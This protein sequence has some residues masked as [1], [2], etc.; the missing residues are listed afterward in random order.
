M[1]SLLPNLPIS[2]LFPRPLGRLNLLQTW[3]IMLFVLGCSACGDET[4]Q[5]IPP[6]TPEMSEDQQLVYL[7]TYTREESHVNGKASGIYA[8]RQDKENGKLE[9]ID[10]TASVI[11]PSFVAF[12]QDGGL[13]YAVSE[14][15][16]GELITYRIGEGAEL[17]EI[18]RNPTDAGAPCHIAVDESDRLIVTS[19]YGGG[20]INV[21]YR[22]EED[23]IHELQRIP[24]NR[25]EGER[26][27]H[28]HSATFSPDNRHV[29]IADL[30]KDKIWGF[31]I[32]EQAIE[33]F[34]VSQAN[35]EQLALNTHIVLEEH[36]EHWLHPELPEPAGPRHFDFHPNGRNAYVINELNATV[37][38]FDYD[39]E[40]GTLTTL[41]TIATLPET[42]TEWNSCADIHVHPSGQ[43][44]FG[45]NR[46]H[47]S[48]VTYRIAED[49]KLS[50][51][52]HTSTGGEF[53]RNFALSP[54]GRYLYAANQN[55]DNILQLEID[56]ETGQLT[57]VA[58]TAT[59]TPVCVAFAPNK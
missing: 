26:A 42:F 44:L 59:L 34:K 13:L 22:D 18:A 2:S 38:A 37:T 52:G 40:N 6:N 54:D 36:V 19:N 29:F 41:Q 27:S 51:V 32:N 8:A 50:L 10:S 16:G 7:G 28:A 3:V 9:L 35:G 39:T 5:E 45:S 25:E 15:G 17:K 43:F 21:F 46:G 55:T 4:P 48:I 23:G 31:S 33:D 24:F 12:S 53:P 20:N 57:P 47:N 56:A 49:G 58:E 30:G 11:N 1:K 14:T